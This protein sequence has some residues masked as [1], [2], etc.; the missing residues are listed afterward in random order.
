[1]RLKSFDFKTAYNKADHDIAGDF[2][3]PCMRSATSYDRI[4]GYF[5]STIYIIAWEALKEF[6]ANKGRMRIICSPY[7]SDEDQKALSEGYSARNNIILANSIKE[8][9]DDLF[10]SPTLSAPARLLAYLVSTDVIDIKIAVVGDMTSA[11]VKRLFHDKVGI[12]TDNIGNAVGFRGSMNE[13]FKGLSSDG[14]IESIDVFPNWV[15]DR[16]KS[17]VEDAQEMFER[18]W[19]NFVED[20]TIFEFPTAAKEILNNIAKDCNWEQLL[21]EIQVIENASQKWKPD[22]KPG[23]NPPRPHQV[24]ALEAWVK[25]GR[26]GILE[27]A[28]GSGKTFTAMCAI[29][30]SLEQ[31][32]TVLVLV[33]S[34]DLLNQWYSELR[35]TITELDIFYLLCGDGNNEWKRLGVLSSWTSTNENQHRIIL[36]T[37]DTA[38]SSTFIRNVV[39]GEH[40][41]IVVDEVHRL[42]SPKRRQALNINSGA[43]LGLSAT[44][45]RYGDPIGTAALIEYFNG[46]IKPPFTLDDAIKSGVLTRYFYHP[47]RLSLTATEQDDWN[48]VTTEIGRIIARSGNQDNITADT[49]NNPVLQRLLIKR[50]R[51]VKNASGKVSLAVETLKRNFKHGQKWIIYCDNIIQLKA[52]LNGAMAAGFDAYEYYADM[53]GDREMTLSYFSINGGVLVSIKCLD[54][55]VDIP[56]TTHAL[57]LASSQ[58]PREFIQRRGRILRRSKNKHFA[59]LYDAITIP[60]MSGSE[61]DKSVSIIMAELSRAIQFG[62][63]AENPACITD[64][65]NIAIDFQVDYNRLKDGGIEDDEE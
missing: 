14:N 17:R 10:A 31:H 50:A 42:G 36:A 63:G 55:G 65:K 61:T 60:E 51:I 27:H 40:L 56:S 33:P 35:K 12:F 41:F 45:Y 46:I 59:H 29:R 3:L 62:Q 23:G 25:N 24:E 7:I 8:E 52:V 57:I 1:M 64:L 16:D 5:G 15:G 19:G 20:V 54:E 44:P 26:R 2:Y 30:D 4:S 11:N 48:D 22:K 53:R 32:E 37:M 34:R 21:N 49:F 13:T 39:Q 43:R 47:Q 6:I 28:T 9:V 58:N 18:L 38:C